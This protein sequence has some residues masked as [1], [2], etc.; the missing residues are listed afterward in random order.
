M[1]FSK[2]ESDQDLSFPVDMAEYDV[3]KELTG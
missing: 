2:K 3:G 1:L